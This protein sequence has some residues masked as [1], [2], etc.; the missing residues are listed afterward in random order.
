MLE[1]IIV[2][3][4]SKIFCVSS[5]EKYVGQQ[6]VKSLKLYRP[7]IQMPSLTFSTPLLVRKVD[8]QSKLSRYSIC[9]ISKIFGEQI[10][11]AIR[12]LKLAAIFAFSANNTFI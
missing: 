9:T 2:V 4:S 1:P 11:T 12:N 5:Y 8:K 6:S 10:V 7:N 3:S